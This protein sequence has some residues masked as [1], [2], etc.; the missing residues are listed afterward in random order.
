M[1]RQ[2]RQRQIGAGEA[3]RTGA[4][5]GRRKVSCFSSDADERVTV[6]RRIGWI[7][8]GGQRAFVLPGEIVGGDLDEQVILVKEAGAPYG[9]RTAINRQ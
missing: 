2:E 5:I 3:E 7:E 6:A 4:V 9:R 1:A 8:V